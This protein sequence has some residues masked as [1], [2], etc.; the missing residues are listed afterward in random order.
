[1]ARKVIFMDDM[2]E[3]L[4]ADAGTI[5]FTMEGISY[6]IDLSTKSAT[7]FRSAMAPYIAAARRVGGKATGTKSKSHKV[8]SAHSDQLNAIR[9]WANANGMQVAYKGRIPADVRLAY[10]Q[11]HAGKSELVQA[12]KV[13]FS[14]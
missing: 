14:G 6:Q 8:S 10:E 13:A 1:M 11:A 12:E 5:S 7:K 9:D 3:T 2:D 4:E